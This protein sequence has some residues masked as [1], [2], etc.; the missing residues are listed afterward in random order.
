MMKLFTI[1]GFAAATA[2]GV[3]AAPQSGANQLGAPQ[4]Q[5]EF[6]PYNPV[7]PK[8]R[9]G[10]RSVPVSEKSIIYVEK[11]IQVCQDVK[12]T[13]CGSCM[14]AIGLKDTNGAKVKGI[15]QCQMKYNNYDVELAR[16][17]EW[18]LEETVCNDVTQQVCNSHWVLEDNGDKVWEEDPT[19]CKNFEVTKC[20]QVQPHHFINLSIELNISTFDL[21]RL[22]DPR[23]VSTMLLPLLAN[24]MRFAVKLS[25][26]SV[27]SSTPKSHN[28][29]RC[30]GSRR[31]VMCPMMS[32]L[33]DQQ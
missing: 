6:D 1:L 17:T 28:N 11:S 8:A 25:G 3:D 33:L 19:T 18:T 21:I 29:K 5:N 9:P 14:E 31:F 7:A 20:E 23:P 26:T 2:L 13:E 22:P 12:E 32:L 4:S 24:L 27:R 30:T 16:S 15:N 10:C